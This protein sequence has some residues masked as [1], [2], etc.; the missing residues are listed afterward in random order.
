M[1]KPALMALCERTRGFPRALEALAAILAADRDASPPGLLTAAQNV[2]PDRV[3]EVL[4]GEAFDH[5]DPLGQQVMQALAV[6]AAPVPPVAVDYLL[7][8]V[9]PAIDSG[10]VLSRLVNMYFAR[11]DEGR[12]YLRQVD[13]D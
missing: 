3:V 11:R 6:Y 1:R 13:R 7:Q 5:L 8:P 9:Q 10:P 4:V 12:Y 2:L